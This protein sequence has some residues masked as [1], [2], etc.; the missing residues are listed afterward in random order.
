MQKQPAVGILGL[1][2]ATPPF[3][4]NQDSYV[5]W[6]IG[7]LG[8]TGEIAQGLQKLSEKSGI[9][10]R[11]FCV[12]EPNK[13]REDWTVLPK[14]FPQTVPSMGVRNK[15]YCAEA[16]KLAIEA[17]KK[18]LA[19]WG[20]NPIDITHVIAVSCTGVMAPGIEYYV[21]EEFGLKKTTQ[22]LGINIMGCFGAFRGI[23]TAKAFA[24]ENPKN[25]ILVV[26]C[27]LCSLHFQTTLSFETFIGNALF[28][29]GAGAFV[30]GVEPRGDERFVWEV[31]ET[32]SMIIESTPNEMTWQ[33]SETGF[34]MSLSMKVPGSLKQKTPEF[35]QSLLGDKCTPAECGWAIH[36][37]GPAVIKGIE[38]ALGIQRSQTQHSWDVLRDYGNMSSATFLFVLD[39]MRK[40]KARGYKSDHMAEEEKGVPEKQETPAMNGAHHDEQKATARVQYAK[41]SAPWIVG[42]GFGPGLSM[43]GVL[44]K[45]V[46]S[47]S[48]L[49][50]SLGNGH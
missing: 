25:R 45:D 14:D 35:S 34:V 5:N 44:L 22:R 18:A 48:P 4:V 28:G 43:E 24:R 19:D 31:E 16:P 3:P 1:G 12:D 29:D 42:L 40:V 33:A 39:E 49:C 20:G 7:S 21:V 30:V 36:P 47:S 37:G 32:A 46:S 38:E 13:K 6:V 8:F 2:T 41:P 11:Y 50:Q 17:C 26:C 10:T 27:E 15:V 9:K 23:A